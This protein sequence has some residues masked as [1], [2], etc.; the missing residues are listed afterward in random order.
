[1]VDDHASMLPTYHVRTRTA[2]SIAAGTK[3]PLARSGPGSWHSAVSATV[4]ANSSRNRAAE[5]V[6]DNEPLSKR[7]VELRE[8]VACEVRRGLGLYQAARRADR[9]GG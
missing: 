9:N 2:S 1:M 3:L 5:T 8:E 6:A 4:L 7:P